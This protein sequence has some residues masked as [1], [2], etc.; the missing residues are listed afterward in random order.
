MSSLDA[1][2]F[3]TALLMVYQ[4]VL[5]IA[6]LPLDYQTICGALF[7]VLSFNMG[8]F[9]YSQLQCSKTISSASIDFKV[10]QCARLCPFYNMEKFVE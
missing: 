1:A 2:S 6:C 7:T 3:L 5:I 4:G 9:P 8:D 10:G